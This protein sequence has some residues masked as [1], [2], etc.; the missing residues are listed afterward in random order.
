MIKIGTMAGSVGRGLAAGVVG[1]AAVTASM[2]LEQ[3]LR[4]QPENTLAAD[5]VQEVLDIR[6]ADE[7][8]KLRLARSMHWLYGTAWGGVRGLLGG[9]GLLGM[10][11]DAA[12]FAAVSGTAMGMPAAL[13]VAPPPQE[14]PPSAMAGATVHHAVYA[15]ATGMAYRLLERETV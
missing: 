3:K 14:Q 4:S 10:A 13:G 5:A 9:L 15:L 6:P 12:H 11:G 1:T 8:A 7:P 2:T